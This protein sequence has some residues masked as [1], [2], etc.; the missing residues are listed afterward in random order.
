MTRGGIAGGL[1][2]AKT[3]GQS[4]ISASFSALPALM[5]ASQDQG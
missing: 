1:E 4:E 3:K 2:D 5:A